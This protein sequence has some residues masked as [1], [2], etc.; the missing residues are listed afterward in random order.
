MNKYNGSYYG[1]PL[2]EQDDSEPDCR[3]TSWSV[4]VD[5]EWH[6]I[7]CCSLDWREQDAAKG[8]INALI[9]GRNRSIDLVT[10][11]LTEA[12]LIAGN[13]PNNESI[14]L[15]TALLKEALNIGKEGQ[16]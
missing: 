11:A 2:M 16:V 13:E 12:Q 4:L 7:V 3:R 10:Q 14:R 1:F 8:L 15:V 5:G 9:K 6:E